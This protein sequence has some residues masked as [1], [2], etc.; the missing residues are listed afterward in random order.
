[1]MPQGR[2][3]RLPVGELSTFNGN[4]RRGQVAVIA[5][6]LRV[7]G[8]YRPIVVNEGS[9]TGRPMEVL[10]GNHTLLAARDLGWD[11]IDVWLVD[12]DGQAAKRIVAADNRTGDLG[13]YDND[14]LFELLSSLDD[15]DGTGYTDTDLTSLEELISGPP[16]LD[17][18]HGDVGDPLEDDNHT[19][20]RLVVEPDLAAVWSA[21]RKSFDDDTGALRAAMNL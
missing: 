6:S 7:S 15:L 13:A 8:Q 1:M 16:D 9:L 10:A 21:H 11:L 4:P 2:A 14:A 12:V 18:L 17:D 19:V 3:N 20:L 5:E